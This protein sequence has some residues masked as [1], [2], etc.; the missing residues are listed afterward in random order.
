[1]INRA[2][3]DLVDGLRATAAQW[4]VGVIEAQEFYDK[5]LEACTRFELHASD[6]HQHA[7]RIQRISQGLNERL[8]RE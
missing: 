6:I 7:H 4:S 5:V 1:M 2:T 8:S 3:Q